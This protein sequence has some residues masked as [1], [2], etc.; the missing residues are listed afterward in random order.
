MCHTDRGRMASRT[1]PRVTAGQEHADVCTSSIAAEYP[2]EHPSSPDGMVLSSVQGACA[3]L[4]NV[5]DCNASLFPWC[6]T[7]APC[8]RRACAGFPLSRAPP[9]FFRPSLAP[10]ARALP[11]Q[12]VF[13]PVQ[14]CH[15]YF[16]SMEMETLVCIRTVAATGTTSSPPQSL[17]RRSPSVCLLLAMQNSAACQ[18]LCY[19]CSRVRSASGTGTAPRPGPHATRPVPHTCSHGFALYV[20]PRTRRDPPA[21]AV[22]RPRGLADV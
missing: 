3:Q 7:V 5:L 10:A 18:S 21:P 2:A 6:L 20:T 4:Y 12:Q 8:C 13:N 14:P 9:P 11:R 1:L 15:L 17:P 22:Q 16:C 19:S